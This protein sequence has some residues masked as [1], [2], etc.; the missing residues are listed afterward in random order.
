MSVFFSPFHD[1]LALDRSALDHVALM[2][3]LHTLG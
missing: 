2:M 3:Q 1:Q